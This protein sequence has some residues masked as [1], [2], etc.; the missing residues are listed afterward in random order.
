[1]QIKKN[2]NPTINIWRKCLD[3]PV[4]PPSATRDAPQWPAR[5]PHGRPSS[6]CRSV[7]GR[8]SAPLPARKAP[9]PLSATL[10]R[11]RARENAGWGFWY[12]FFK[13]NR[14]GIWT[15]SRRNVFQMVWT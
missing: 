10:E 2:L 7:G 6:L 14:N 15:L 1:M 4:H 12:I 3:G 5:Q 9:A 11:E 8:R 13:R